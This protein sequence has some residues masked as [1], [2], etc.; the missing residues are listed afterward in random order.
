MP[1]Y[2]T[3]LAAGL[4][5]LTLALGLSGCGQAPAEVRITGNDNMQYNIDSFTV[6]PGQTVKLTLAHVGTQSRENMGHNVVI[7][8][9]DKN[10][11]TFASRAQQGGNLE[12]GFLPESVM[13]GVIAHTRMLGG[14]ESQTITFTAPTTPGEYPFV[15]T[16]T[17]HGPTMNGDMIV[18]G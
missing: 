17:G 2:R 5:A 15:C 6:K 3:C 16:F 10:P 8:K 4:A 12:N 11:L 14:G 18:K 13:D 7:L 9:R 1:R